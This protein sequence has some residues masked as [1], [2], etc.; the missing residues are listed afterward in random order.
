MRVKAIVSSAG[1]DCAENDDCAGSI[2]TDAGLC[3]WVIDGATNVA[4]RDYLR[5]GRGDVAWYASALSKR[6]QANAPSGLALPELHAAA[7]RDVAEDYRELRRQLRAPPP[8]YAQPMAALTMVRVSDGRA[9]LYELGD[10]PAFALGGD[11]R[12]RRLTT[13]EDSEEADESRTRVTAAQ[14]TVGYAPK[15]V[16]T[17]RL[18]SLRRAREVSMSA[19]PLRVSTPIADAAFGG[20]SASFDLAGVAALVLMSDGFERFAAKYALGDDAEMVRRSIE[21]GPDAPLAALRAV[22]M[23]DPDCRRFPRLKPSDDATCVVIG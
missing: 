22:E 12:V 13:H 7:V 4:G 20:F 9:E 10:C 17:D 11:G 19:N 16:W 8:F 1:L 15:A 6:L 5:A 2:E 23:A 3:A 18:P 14:R 21:E